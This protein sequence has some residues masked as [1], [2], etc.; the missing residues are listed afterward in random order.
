MAHVRAD[1]LGDWELKKLQKTCLKRKWRSLALSS[2]R[3]RKLRGMGAP[4]GEIWDLKSPCT[5]AFR[6]VDPVSLSS[7]HS[8]Q[9]CCWLS[10][11]LL[12]TRRGDAGAVLLQAQ[13]LPSPSSRQGKGELC[14]LPAPSAI[15]TRGPRSSSPKGSHWCLVSSQTMLLGLTRSGQCPFA[16]TYLEAKIFS[17]FLE[18][19]IHFYM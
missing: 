16:F 3:C 7:V 8:G 17:Y 19:E 9:C 4:I 18:L 2:G 13:L 6:G 12:K 11:A 15:P 1:Y 5:A 14:L 10:A